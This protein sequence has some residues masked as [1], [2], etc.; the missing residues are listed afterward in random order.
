MLKTTDEIYFADHLT[1]AYYSQVRLTD[2]IQGLKGH[3]FPTDV[4]L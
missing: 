1:L 3:T 4:L 2:S